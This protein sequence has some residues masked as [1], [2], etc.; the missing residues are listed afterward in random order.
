MNEN[1]DINQES[2]KYYIDREDDSISC[3]KIVSLRIFGEEKRF[4]GSGIAYC[5]KENIFNETFGKTLAEVRANLAVLRQIEISLIKYTFDHFV[6]DEIEAD[7]RCLN[8]MLEVL[9][10]RG[11]RCY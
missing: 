3:N 2:I 4:H 6:K 7:E 1:I 5:I 10:R 8:G 11:H 9:R